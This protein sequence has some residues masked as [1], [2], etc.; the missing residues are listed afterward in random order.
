MMKFC[1]VNMPCNLSF[2]LLFSSVQF[3]LLMI[4]ISRIVTFLA[5]FDNQYFLFFA[6]T[7]QW[8]NNEPEKIPCLMCDTIF[9]THQMPKLIKHL[10][11]KHTNK[12]SKQ[13]AEE[14]AI[15]D[16]IDQQMVRFTNLDHL[17]CTQRVFWFPISLVSNIFANSSKT[18]GVMHY[19]HLSNTRRTWNKQCSEK[20][21]INCLKM[22]ME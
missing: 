1:P 21:C 22:C 19:S 9:E 11:N 16:L 3:N 14:K 10:I 17:R 7:G 8:P 12:K 20:I 4:F 6:A 13:L 15:M 18:I 5:L 2:V